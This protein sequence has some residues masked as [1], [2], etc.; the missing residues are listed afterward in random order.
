MQEMYLALVLER[1]Y[2]KKN[3]KIKIAALLNIHYATLWSC[4]TS[5]YHI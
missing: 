3:K 2:F 4:F 1:N 5:Y